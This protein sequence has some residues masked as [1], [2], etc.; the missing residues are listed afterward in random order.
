[1]TQFLNETRACKAWSLPD[2]QA[3]NN[4]LTLST[5]TM[6]LAV[7][8][9][10][11]VRRASPSRARKRE[12]TARS[13]P[14]NAGSD[15]GSPSTLRLLHLASASLQHLHNQNSAGKLLDIA[16]QSWC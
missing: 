8:Q 12:S 7:M 11:A 3:S 13:A 10:D 15:G 14:S 5:Q 9:T 16:E 4:V 6:R 1:M 2:L